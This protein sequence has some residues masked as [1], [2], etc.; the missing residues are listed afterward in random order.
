MEWDADGYI[1][2]TERLGLREWRDSDFEPF[3]YQNL[4]KEVMR[5]FPGVYSPAASM[6]SIKRYQ[7][8]IAD[9]GFGLYAVDY[10]L[11]NQFIGFIGLAIPTFETSFT[12]CV[13]VGYRLNRHYWGH[14]LATEGARACLEYAFNNIGLD[15]IY[16]YTA[17]PN[18]PSQRVMV[19]IGMRKWG[20]FEH[21]RIAEGH[22]LKTHVVYMIENKSSN[23]GRHE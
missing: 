21:P 7:Q 6:S 2:T 11:N 4:D 19:K 3:A 15:R 8:Q 9:N 12:P 1:I 20:S 16:S 18:V 23:G 13:E 14:G 17:V 22:E 10:L 5:Y